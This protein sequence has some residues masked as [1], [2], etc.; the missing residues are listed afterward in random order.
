M[1]LSG[2]ESKVEGKYRVGHSSCVVTVME[3]WNAEWHSVFWTDREAF[4]KYEGVS[5]LC[6]TLC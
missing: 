2:G 5:P 4:G 6:Q 3:T 1:L